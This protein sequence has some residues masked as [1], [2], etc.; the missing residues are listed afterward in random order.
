MTQIKPRFR[1][2]EEYLDYDD[3]TDTRYE[4]VNGELVEL[5][6][7]SRL[8]HKIASF[9]FEVFIRLGIS[10]TLLTIG[11]QIAVSSQ[12]VTARQP[13]FVVLSPEC[14]DALEG[15]KS[16]LITA[17]MPVP[18]LVVEV[19]SPGNPGSENYDRDYVEK[20]REYA[21]RG[22]PEFWRVD[23]ERTLVTVLKLEGGAYQARDFRGSDAVVSRA[24]PDLQL[25][26]E[27][28]LRAGR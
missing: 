20:P 22:I 11:V 9:L 8:N 3:G 12:E 1:S 23:P 27:Q 25:T 2:L 19:V 10:S 13:D 28:I 18:D 15:L 21:V 17:E 16:D 26:A 5:P 14:A 4:L 24:F 7:E 6:P